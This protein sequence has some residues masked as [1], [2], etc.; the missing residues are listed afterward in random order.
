MSASYAGVAHDL[1]VVVTPE[2]GEIKAGDE[3]R[4]PAPSRQFEFVLNAGLRLTGVAPG[5][6]DAVGTSRDGLRTRWRVTLPGATD[7]LSVHYQGVPRFSARRGL[8]DMPQGVVASEGVY[9]D[10]A[11]AWY[12][13][14]GEPIAGL[15]LAVTLPEGWQAVSIGRRGVDAQGRVTWTTD[16][17]HD[18]VYLVAGRYTRHA[19]R[20]GT[21]DLSVWLL[22]DDPELAGRYLGVMGDYLDHYSRLI[23][24]YPYAKFAVVENRWQTGYGMPS[25]TLLGSRVMR[26]PFI[27]YTSLPHEILHNWWGNG[28][29]VDY[30]KGNWSEGLTAYLADH[31]MQER[32]GQGADYRLRA[33]QRYTNFAAA[34]DDAPLRA[35]VSRHSDAS[36][37]IGYSKSL[38]L[39]HMV[40]RELG[41]QAFIEGLQRVWREHR[42]SRVGFAEVLAGLAGGDADRFAQWLDRPGAPRLEL[43]DVEVTAGDGAYRLALTL[44][45]VQSAPFRFDLPIVVTY[46][47]GGAGERLTA[48]VSQA[49][50]RLVFDLPHRPLRIDVDPAHDVLRQLDPSEQPPALNRLFGGNARLIL[51]DSATPAM[52][53][54]WRLLATQWRERYPGLKVLDDSEPVRLGG[55]GDHIVLGWDNRLLSAAAGRV[56]RDGQALSPDQATVAGRSFAASTHAIVLVDSDR[57]GNTTA[58]IGAPSPEAVAMLARKLPHYGSYGRLVFDAASGENLLKEALAARF[59]ILT[60]QLGTQAVRAAVLPDPMLDADRVERSP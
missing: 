56:A 37:S 18:D 16:V 60:R 33:L 52:R 22:D 10:G 15:R 8:G 43:D 6:A 40:R 2:R 17:P 13:Q 5:R 1:A 4:L 39:F 50:Q 27:P 26:L 54:A 46:A 51:P 29:W 45:Q 14:T 23:G 20:H 31:W 12:P 9:L 32:K 59:S 38:M 57:D 53:D 48:T 34:G 7:R 42:F 30:A 19:R 58:F 21:I 44:R 3:I 25:F 36:Q 55:R 24:P 47:D 11:S 49:E 28:V 35:F 41:D